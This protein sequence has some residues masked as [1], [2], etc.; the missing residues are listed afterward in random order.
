MPDG[1]R[2]RYTYLDLY[3]RVKKLA[4]V[5]VH[6]LGIQPGDRVATFAWNHYQHLE[7]YYA[8]PGVGAICHTLNLRLSSEQV[9]F[10]AG[11]AEDKLVF[12]DASL[13]PFF[14]QIAPFVPSVQH[15]ILLNA[16]PNFKTSLPNILDYDA[17][18]E[19][20]SEDFEW[21]TVDENQAC[22]MCYTSGTTG[23][24]KG[25]LYSH[26]S[27]YLHALAAL[28]VNAMGISSQDRL[29][30]IVPMFHAMAWGTPFVAILAGADIVLP[31]CHLHCD[32]LVELLATEKIT[33]ANGVPTIWINVYE[34]LMKDPRKEKLRLK[35]IICGGSTLPKALIQGFEKNFGIHSVHLW[36]MTETSPLGTTS[37]LQSIHQDLSEAEQYAIRAK[38]GIE[39]PGVEIQLV[40]EEGAV[41]PRDGKTMG[42]LYVR[43]PWIAAGYYKLQ[44]NSPFFTAD[45]WFKTGDVAT[46]DEQGYMQITDRTKDL[47][48]SGGEWISSVALEV[49]LMGHPKVK[50]ACV[51]AVPHEKWV[52]RPMACIVPIA[53][54]EVG[55]EELR[56]FLLKDFA[57][58]QIPD[59]FVLVPEIPK[60]SVGKFNKKELRRLH[61]LGALT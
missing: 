24:P 15:Y 5:L 18:M 17:L 40:T 6:Q 42:E 52:E 60:T 47:I 43:G 36:G 31:S 22:A 58:Y 28:S 27:T 26:R 13:V 38:Q 9:Q 19:A 12:I 14:E 29:L 61:A 30:V 21:V 48:K 35:E 56:T 39:V 32:A 3:R 7:L 1:S 49:A 33:V 4:N 11:H 34:L 41:A 46:I 8:I 37:R 2:H 57:H 50:E 55:A 51:I 59:H 10:I 20:A 23:N 25:V 44:D 53:G 45:G 54:A 16:P